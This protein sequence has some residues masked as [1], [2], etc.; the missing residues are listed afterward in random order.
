MPREQ[1][2]T[3]TSIFAAGSYSRRETLDLYL[4]NGAILRLSR[5]AVERTAAGG[6]AIV[7]RDCIRQIGELNSSIEK[8]IDRITVRCQNVDSVLGLNLASG[9]RLLDYAFADYGK[10]YQSNAN[11]AL[12]EDI[13]RVFP[14]VVA[15]AN[16]SRASIEFDLIVDYEALWRTVSARSMSPKCDA[17]YKVSIHIAD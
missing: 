15:G 1:S 11:P 4:A 8:P 2:A 14:G 12:V 3:L 17:V 13:P 10:I 6:Q 7:Y 16:V 9:S 5:G